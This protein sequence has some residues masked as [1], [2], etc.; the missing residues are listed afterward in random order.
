MALR[1]F[2]GGGLVGGLAYGY[3]KYSIVTRKREIK[4]SIYD[5]QLEIPGATHIPVC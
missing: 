1:A 4:A 5:V 3:M 2:V